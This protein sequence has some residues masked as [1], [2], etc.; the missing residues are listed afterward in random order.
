MN[1]ATLKFC[2]FLE[3]STVIERESL[4]KGGLFF[5]Q[6]SKARLMSKCGLQLKWLESSEFIYTHT[7]THCTRLVIKK[8]GE[9]IK[10]AGGRVG[11]R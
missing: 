7:P 2:G 6:G 9:R 3:C 10:E 1:E 8:T 11:K 5:T 4:P